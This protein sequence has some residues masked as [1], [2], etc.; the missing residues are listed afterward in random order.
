MMNVT[1]VCG[2]A[3]Q[4]HKDTTRQKLALPLPTLRPKMAQGCFKLFQNDPLT[5][6]GS[7][8]NELRGKMMQNSQYTRA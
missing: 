8:L 7:S 2:L 5:P 6:L 4:Q 3:T 1:T